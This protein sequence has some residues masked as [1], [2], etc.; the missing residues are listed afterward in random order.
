M[1][2]APHV[3]ESVWWNNIGFRSDWFRDQSHSQTQQMACF[4]AAHPD[5]DGIPPLSSQAPPKS[6]VPCKLFVAVQTVFLKRPIVWN[7]KT[8]Q[9]VNVICC[10]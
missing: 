8:V 2:D 5:P 10:L 9:K 1:V 3:K 4:V 6:Q 7:G